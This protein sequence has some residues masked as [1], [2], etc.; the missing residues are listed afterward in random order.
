[1]VYIVCGILFLIFL[2]CLG[3]LIVLNNAIFTAKHIINPYIEDQRVDEFFMKAAVLGEINSFTK[4]IGEVER[5]C[6][7]YEK[8][9]SIVTDVLLQNGYNPKQYNLKG[10][11]LLA[12]VKLGLD[13]IPKAGDSNGE[14]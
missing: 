4:D 2:S 6:S 14:G 1:M 13:K 8:S 11:V 7:A 3:C 9:M 12:R 5:I 10:L